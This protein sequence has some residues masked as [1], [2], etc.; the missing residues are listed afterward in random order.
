MLAPNLHQHLGWMADLETLA[1]ANS[2]V[3]PEISLVA[4]EIDTGKIVHEMTLHLSVDEQLQAGRTVSSGT[5]GFWLTQTQEARDKLLLAMD[6]YQNQTIGKL[7]WGVNEA[8][9]HI[10]DTVRMITYQWEI[11]NKHKI[12]RDIDESGPRPLIYGNGARFDC[13]KVA[14]LYE[15]ANRENDYPWGYSGDRDIRT[16]HSLAPS[17]KGQEEFEGIP[18]F[19]LDDCKHQIKYTHKIYNAILEASALQS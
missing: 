13:G 19:G 15:R 9:T 10:R 14:D 2:A 6:D 8:L 3:V 7:P 17:F 16:L 11:Q 12:D 1:T 4:F 18:H 5:L